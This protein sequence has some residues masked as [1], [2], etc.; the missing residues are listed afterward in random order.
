MMGVMDENDMKGCF[1]VIDNS[2]LHHS[3]F[4]VNAMNSFSF[5]SSILLT[6]ENHGCEFE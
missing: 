3:R 2:K 6:T 4:G 1:I 5:L